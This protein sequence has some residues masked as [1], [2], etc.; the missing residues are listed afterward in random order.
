M[1]K[2]EKC[3]VV[4]R[5][6]KRHWIISL[7]LIAAAGGGTWWALGHQAE[8]KDIPAAKADSRVL[9][10][11]I[12]Y[13]VRY[14]ELVMPVEGNIE[15][16]LVHEGEFVRKG[17]PL[18]RLERQDYQAR[19]GGAQTDVSK[20]AAVIDQARVNLED[21]ERE[22]KRLQ[23][24]KQAGAIA[25]QQVEQA[26]TTVKRNQALLAQAQADYATQMEKVTEAGSLLDKTELR[27]PLD[28][29]IAFLEV[30][31]GERAA[32][33]VVLVRV[34]DE[35]AWEIRSDDLTELSVAKIKPGDA[36]LITVDGIPGLEIP[37]KVTFI[38]PFG[39]KKRGDMTYTVKVVPD[40]WDSRILWKMTVQLAIT[41]NS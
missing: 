34:A 6:V 7:L 11:G 16:V 9:A 19:I 29:K 39:E 24:L 2:G 21:A 26:E 33:G 22:L 36:A 10:Q 31:P 40:K 4:W 38:R 17:Q 27:S 41:S 15:E 13:P 14:A 23:Q 12:V 32:A 28:G 20:F 3:M 8:K 35:S 5:L 25:R 1:N 37:G 18:I 30:N